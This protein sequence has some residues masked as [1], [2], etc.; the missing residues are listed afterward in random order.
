MWIMDTNEAE[1][2]QDRTRTRVRQRLGVWTESPG[3]GDRKRRKVWRTED[4]RRVVRRDLEELR[5][6]DKWTWRR[7]SVELGRLRRRGN[8]GIDLRTR[9]E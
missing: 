9:G 3:P 8:E 5:L 4:P 1:R 6:T 7:E 2:P